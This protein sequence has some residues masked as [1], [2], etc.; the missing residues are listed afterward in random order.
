MER[1]QWI[2][3]GGVQGVGFR[4]FVY[5]AAL[6]AGITGTIANTSEGVV[7]EAQG[8]SDALQEFER[9]FHQTLPPLARIVDWNRAQ[10]AP[11]MEEAAFTIIKST[12]GSGHQ[13]LISPDVATCNDCLAD[14]SDPANRRFGYP[15][16]NCTNCGPRYTITRSIPYDRVSTSMACFPLC[17]D[18]Q[19]EYEDPLD[20]RFHAQPNACPVCG[21]KI[22]LTNPEGEAIAS[23][24]TAL[25]RTVE[26]LLDGAIVAMKGLGG[27]HLVCDARNEIAVAKLRQRKNRK[28]K[29]LAIMVR[30]QQTAQNYCTTTGQE[31]KILN[32]M[33]RPIVLLKAHEQN[34][35]PEDLSP[36]TD[37]LGLMLPYTP[38]HH[39]LFTEL[40]RQNHTS[41][42]LVMTSGNASS[43][44]I[45]LGN[46][47]ALARLA[48]IA[49]A[50]LFHNRD[51]LI[52]C[53]DSVVR[54]VDGQRQFLRRA[55]G[56][57]PSPIMLADKGP[58]VLGVGPLLKNTLCLTKGA[59]AF[60][61]QH[62]GDL[63]NLGTFQ[64]F[65]EIAAHLQDILQVRPEA[66]VHDLHP[67]FMSTIY[68]KELGIPTFPLQHHFA[69]IHAVLAENRHVGP[70]IGLALDGT[71]LGDDGTVWGGEALWV[72]PEK[73]TQ[74]RLGRFSAVPLPGGDAAIREPWR[75]ARGYLHALGIAAPENRPWPW[76]EAYSAA[77]RITAQ[78]LARGFN[79]PLTSSCGRLFDAVSAML[80]LVQRIS[81]EGQA[82]IKLEAIQD[83]A[84]QGTYVCPVI[85]SQNILELDT[86]TLFA[87][88]YADWQSGLEPGRISR[89]FHMGLIEGLGNL[90]THLAHSQ[91]CAII[92]LS[93]G[94]MQNATMA[95]ELP[96]LLAA[97]GLKVLMHEHLPPN[98]ACISLG[99]AAY[100][101]IIMAN[102]GV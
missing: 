71:G 37:F 12:G 79:C 100:G 34:G 89:K 95:A 31:E 7:L 82:A 51:I 22:W 3:T 43:E 46:R 75:I 69:H 13:V 23:G 88:V 101:R 97:Q 8:T 70:A 45:C 29:P 20:R 19:R 85:E 74:N 94:V 15:F 84:E 62:I 96:K 90:A 10:L 26:M 35:L 48:N 36:D 52:R 68:A 102:T 41:A 6:L 38:L 67:D 27:F 2:I 57:T 21:P 32:G 64:F 14:M 93:G 59:Q 86:R 77:D 1:I 87:Q 99:Q 40:T 81:Y 60:V 18:C 28:D 17:P 56:Y 11:I 61:S 39:E 91:Q 30:D 33:E 83:V 47:E 5:K 16:T 55:R 80:G 25:V 44:P 42:A 92:A 66:V 24:T 49:D 58:C 78:M 63:E 73:C 72:H 65:K 54:L 9:I 53:D 76:L 4:P 50:F 98:D